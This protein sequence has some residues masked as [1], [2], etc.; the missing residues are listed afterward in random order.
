M[1]TY[2][3]AYT[4]A[5]ACMFAYIYIYVF[6]VVHMYVYM[7]ITYIYFSTSKLVQPLSSGTMTLAS[8]RASAGISSWGCGNSMTVLRM[9]ALCRRL[10]VMI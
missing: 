4:Y 1:C 5:H 6:M 3:Y 10:Y 8:G 7:Y 2:I 9:L